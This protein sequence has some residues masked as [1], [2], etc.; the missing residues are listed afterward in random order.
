MENL[1]V[2]TVK[3]ELPHGNRIYG[4]DIMRAVAIMMVVIEHGSTLRFLGVKMGTL[5]VEIF[6][7]LSGFLIGQI[8]LRD[9]E[10]EISFP[11]LLNFWKRRWLRTIPVYYLVLLI[12]MILAPAIGLNILFYFLFLQNN[13][14]GIDFFG[15]SWSLVIEEW[16][17]LLIPFG[18]FVLFKGKQ[19]AGKKG[20]SF[21]LMLV[22]AINIL[23]LVWVYKRNTPFGGIVGQVPLRM[24]TMLAGVIMAYVKRYGKQLFGFL[25]GTPQFLVSL[26]LFL[27]YTSF[28]GKATAAGT[29]DTSFWFR[30]GHFIT[31]SLS[32]AL[33]IPF[34]D[35]NKTL[36]ATPDKQIFRKLIT[37]I[38]LISYSLYL[39]HTEIA[40]LVEA[41]AGLASIGLNTYV[42]AMVLAFACSTLLYLYFEKPILRW[43][44]RQKAILQS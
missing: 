43:R 20:L 15:V 29:L 9:F 18:I 3:T 44:D 28:W 7:V 25:A 12:K 39:T 33:L 38:S 32:I 23:K 31:L 41:S 11:K 16:F 5:G 26:L 24:D 34:L 42:F 30:T 2:Q 8:L 35:S 14:Y 40:H 1:S 17:Y 4:L 22:V 6:F 37:W 21:L 10:S 36:N 13:F 27:L 19:F